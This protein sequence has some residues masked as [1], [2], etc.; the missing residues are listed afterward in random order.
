MGLAGLIREN[1]KPILFALSG[2]IAVVVLVAAALDELIDWQVQVAIRKN[3]EVRALNWAENFFATTP[4]SRRMVEKG[5]ATPSELDRL[6]SSF[7]LVDVIRFEMF[8]REGVRTLLSDKGVL[9][10]S[11]AVNATAV[12]VYES[13]LPLVFVHE[14]EDHETETSQLETYVEVYL[15]AVLPSGEAIGAIEVYV[16]VTKF[17]DEL[18]EVFQQISGYLILGTL[19]IGLFPAAAY[20]RTTRQ[21]MRK[22]KQLLELTRYDKLTGIYNRDT[23]STYLARFFASPEAGGNLGILFVDVDYFKQV[24]DQYGHAAGDKLLQ[25]IASVLNDCIRTETDLI[26]RYGGDEFVILMPDVSRGLFRER[27]SLILEASQAPYRHKDIEF[28]PSLSVGAYLTNTRDTE[29]SALHKADLAVYAA[30]RSGRGQVVEYTPKLEG[31]FDQESSRQ[32]A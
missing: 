30:K 15:P 31:L 26:G 24:N 10:P 17:E 22:D 25:H 9:E 20:I 19:L 5:V 7:A 1:R 21:I 4:S 16:D 27:C 6:E 3:A 29:K 28:V 32:S 23:V 18:E 11:T 13:G 12:R 14:K 8:N 2:T